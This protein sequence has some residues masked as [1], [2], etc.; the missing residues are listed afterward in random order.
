M[1][2]DS[3]KKGK[4][5]EKHLNKVNME[6]WYYIY[7]NFIKNDSKEKLKKDSKDKS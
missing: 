5:I 4:D 3:T 2:T 7:E 6:P 1:T